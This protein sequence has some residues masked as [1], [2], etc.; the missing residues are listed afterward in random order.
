MIEDKEL[1]EIFRQESDEHLQHL[2]DILLR[3]ES[4]PENKALVE[5]V[6]REAHSLKGAA[7]MINLTK[8]ENLAHHV[9]DILGSSLKGETTLTP[10]LF[11]T[12]HHALDVIKGLVMEAVSGEG[13]GGHIS[14]IIDR[15]KSGSRTSKKTVADAAPPEYEN[16]GLPVNYTPLTGLDTFRIESIRI[17]TKKLDELLTLVGE[18][19][20]TRSRTLH[21]LSEIKEAM[22]LWDTISR[23]ISDDDQELSGRMGNILNLLKNGIFEDSS[24][25]DLVCGDLEEK[26]SATRLLP[27]NT[28]F[29]LFPRM[30]R[31]IARE[32]EME[33]SLIM[34]G[35]DTRVDKRI[36]E[37]MKDPL[38]HLI[39]NA[40]DHG[41]EDG[42]KR[43]S[44]GKP[45]NGTIRLTASQNGES[46]IL[47]I[48]DD[49]RGMDAES[50]RQTALKTKLEKKEALEAMNHDEIMNLVFRPGF[51]T[52]SFVS[53]LSGRGVGLDVVKTNVDRLKGNIRVLSIPGQGTTFR[54]Q[55]PVTLAT[56]RVMIAA[57]GD[58][59]Y[60]VPLEQ[61]EQTI[62]IGRTDIFKVEGKETVN[63]AGSPVSVVR[64]FDVL[65]LNLQRSRRAG[66]RKP[67]SEAI[68]CVVI[69]SGGHRLGLLVDE[70]VD[71]QEVVLKPQSKILKRVRNISGATILGTGEICM[72]L[73]PGDIIKTVRRSE[74][75][76]FSEGT[77][78]ENDVMKKSVLAAEDSL[79]TRT[80]MKRILE[81][82]G[83]EV[84]TAVDG[85]DAY[86]KLGT[87]NFN[88]LVT[89]VLM[90]NMDGLTL[91]AKVRQEKKYSE[92]PI[93]LVTSLALD[94]DRK[95]GVEAGA[96]A[97]ITK[98]GFDQKTFLDTLRRL[99]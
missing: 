37:E 38:M 28:L 73:S 81:G 34:E 56:L 60:G 2:G 5:E 53:D 6:F 55:L 50:I 86:N 16:L 91:T 65:G 35:E 30:L 93:I 87:R 46:V 71:E 97:Y 68:P 92:M 8:I 64:L 44:L 1:R 41:M 22:S 82:A 47:E 67:S 48:S 85:L 27:M 40:L 74:P 75:G 54:I 69:S 19:N 20:V 57:I 23:R 11:D 51:S 43:V 14:D 83:Y 96:N 84:V 33:V 25:L 66:N 72:I 26:I 63:I 77:E 7:R 98:P 95:K 79:T 36:I 59:K 52:S 18:L 80:Q 15:L 32:R 42:E 31:E 61:I 12:L 17:E 62:M 21:R 58:L 29:N 76:G 10:A 89:D 99:I 90:P 45:A 9:E 39:R 78:A 24:K 13:G 70:M 49:G 94:E 4:E 88:A 3:L